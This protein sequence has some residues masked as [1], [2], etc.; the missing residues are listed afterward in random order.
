M[1]A[2]FGRSRPAVMYSNGYAVFAG[3]GVGGA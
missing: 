2:L 3:V 1:L